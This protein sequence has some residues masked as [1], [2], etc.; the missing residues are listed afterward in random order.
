MKCCDPVLSWIHCKPLDTKQAGR[1]AKTVYFSSSAPIID[2][3]TGVNHVEVFVFLAVIMLFSFLS[4]SM[5]VKSIF[6]EMLDMSLAC[7]LLIF[8]FFT[9]TSISDRMHN[10]HIN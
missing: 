8:T 6:D 3:L 9:L 7:L 5:M 2:K 4:W 10:W 1:I